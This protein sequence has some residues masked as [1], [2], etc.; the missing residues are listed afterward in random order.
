MVHNLGSLKIRDE[1]KLLQ[2]DMESFPGIWHESVKLTMELWKSI[3]RHGTVQ[4]VLGLLD[5]GV[6]N[7]G[8]V[9]CI[10]V[11]VDQSTVKI[12]G[13]DENLPFKVE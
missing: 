13:N 11:A 10:T 2:A 8:E 1:A 4:K 9:L 12:G 7:R 3:R 5:S 6:L